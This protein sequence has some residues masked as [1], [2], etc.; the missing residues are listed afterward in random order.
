MFPGVLDTLLYG[1]YMLKRL[2]YVTD[3][4]ILFFKM[5]ILRTKLLPRVLIQYFSFSNYPNTR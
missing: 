2:S 1:D 4:F 5:T 3:A